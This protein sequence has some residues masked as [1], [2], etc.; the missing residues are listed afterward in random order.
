MNPPHKQQRITLSYG[1][2]R[3]KQLVWV[4]FSYNKRI[5]D[6]IKEFGGRWSQSNKKWYILKDDFNLH[7]FF[8][9]FKDFAWLDYSALKATEQA[10]IQKSKPAKRPVTKIHDSLPTSKENEIEAFVHWMKQKRYAANTIKIYNSCLT[11]F[12]C[13]YPDKPLDEIGPAEIER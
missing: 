10:P 11:T 13:Y 6:Q 7:Y 1:Q 9:Q 3:G 12:F 2:Q 5:V 4:D 8:V